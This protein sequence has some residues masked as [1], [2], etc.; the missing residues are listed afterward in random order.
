MSVHYNADVAKHIV[1]SGHYVAWYKLESIDRLGITPEIAL[2]NP[3]RGNRSVLRA[4]PVYDGAQPLLA[5][6]DDPLIPD[7]TDIALAPNG[8]VAWISRRPAPDQNLEVHFG[9][10]RIPVQPR[11]LDVAPDIVPGSLALGASD[12]Y[13]RRAD[14]PHS[15]SRNGD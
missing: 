5:Q 6:P 13:W 10:F 8:S 12:V 9:R 14:G 4:Y 3:R 15:A 11:T 7:I 2:V 1:V